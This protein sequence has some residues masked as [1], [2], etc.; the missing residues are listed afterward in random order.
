MAVGSG[1]SAGSN[2]RAFVGDLDLETVDVETVRDV[3]LFGTVELVAV[4]DGVDEG[5][6]ERQLDAEDV[7]GVSGRGL[8]KL[9]DRVL[10]ATRLGRVADD[11][12]VGGVERRSV[13]GW[14][15]RGL[16]DDDD[17]RLAARDDGGEH[18]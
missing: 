14:V 18:A 11:H 15:H 12:D 1:T 2:P 3:D 5:L 6:L 10:D 16:F 4:L 7:V 8:Q 9:L 13:Q 17:P